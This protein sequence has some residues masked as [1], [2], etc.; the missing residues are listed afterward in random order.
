MLTRFQ[1]GLRALINQTNQEN[2]SDTPDRILAQYLDVC[3]ANFNTAVQHRE[4]WYGRAHGPTGPHPGL[5]PVP[6]PEPDSLEK[7][8]ADFPWLYGARPK[9]T[10]PPQ[11]PCGPP[12]MEN[13]GCAVTPT[14]E[15]PTPSMT[16]EQ[17]SRTVRTLSSL[18]PVDVDERQR[19]ISA[20]LHHEQRLQYRM[21][22]M[23]RQV[24]DAEE[25]IGNYQGDV[26]NL[27][28]ELLAA[29]K[30]LE[31][32]A[33]ELEQERES[34][35]WDYPPAMAEARINQ[36]VQQLSASERCLAATQQNLEANGVLYRKTLEERLTLE[37]QA[38]ERAQ[39]ITCLQ[40]VGTRHVQ[41]FRDLQQE[42]TEIKEWRDAVV[43][44]LPIPV[45]RQN[46]KR[47]RWLF[48]DLPQ[49]PL[50]T[51]RNLMLARLQNIILYRLQGL[52]YSYSVA[53]TEIDA[54]MATDQK[55]HDTS[56]QPK[57][58]A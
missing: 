53:C 16:T 45:D 20:I 21:G 23:E 19:A 57:E 50:R 55:A 51:R 52:G 3:L 12:T 43:P 8:K 1:E 37:E 46:T 32:M 44:L 28:E 47:L 42:L 5:E 10:P 7:I 49:G 38:A 15:P 6:A 58:P 4:A 35:I 13:C 56:P 48:D 40:E 14:P 24:Y 31:A 54:E 9:A 41:E 39:Q 2:G 29:R 33:Q 34:H 18:S 17:Y 25:A 36:L 22:M 27:R 26:H 30:K 11:H